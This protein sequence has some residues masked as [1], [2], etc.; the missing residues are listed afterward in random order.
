MAAGIMCAA[1]DAGGVPLYLGQYIFEPDIFGRCTEPRHGWPAAQAETCAAEA[2]SGV[3]AVVAAY[4]Y[5]NLIISVEVVWQ[6]RGQVRCRVRA[7][8]VCRGSV[9][10]C[11]WAVSVCR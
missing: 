10:V 7:A 9:M 1:L 6:W 3:V 4:V 2:V 5:Y 11:I 8:K